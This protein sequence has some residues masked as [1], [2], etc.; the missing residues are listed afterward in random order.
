[1]AYLKCLAVSSASES[2]L[3]HFDFLFQKEKQQHKNRITVKKPLHEDFKDMLFFPERSSF[4][5]R[6][7]SNKN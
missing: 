5:F 3:H 2:T 1:M 7:D 4:S 6:D